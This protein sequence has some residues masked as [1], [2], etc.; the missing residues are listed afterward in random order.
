MANKPPVNPSDYFFTPLE[1]ANLM[2]EYQVR[3]QR[4]PGITFGVPSIDKVLIPQRSGNVVG[5]IARPGHGKSSILAYLAIRTAKQIVEQ[6]PAEPQCVVYITLENS[7]EE[8]EAMFMAEAPWSNRDY[9]EGLVPDKDF[10]ARYF[11]RTKLPIWVIGRSERQAKKV[12]F[13]VPNLYAAISAMGTEFDIKPALILLD[14][15]QIVPSQKAAERLEQV[16]EAIIL[17]KELALTVGAPINVGVQASR[18]VDK[19]DDHIPDIADCQ[20]SSALEQVADKLFGWWRPWLTR[21]RSA[22]KH[23]VELAGQSVEVTPNLLVG[24]LAKQRM[25]DAGNLFY[26]HFDPAYVKLAEMELSLIGEQAHMKMPTPP[27]NGKDVENGK[28]AF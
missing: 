22:M 3:V 10:M 7:V 8:M 25:A 16:S 19:R 20:W 17:S 23:T 4:E 2:A 13:S 12:D 28:I 24:R 27:V 15:I 26:L 9:A 6:P 5:H 14:Y 11:W 1:S 21:K 18:G